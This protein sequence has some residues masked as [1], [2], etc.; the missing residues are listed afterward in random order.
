MLASLVHR[1]AIDCH[2]SEGTLANALQCLLHVGELHVKEYQFK[3]ASKVY[4]RCAEICVEKGINKGS[5]R[6]Y[7]YNALLCQFVVSARKGSLKNMSSMLEWFIDIDR[8]FVN[9]W[10]EKLLRRCMEAFEHGDPQ[11]LS[12][13]VYDQNKIHKL[14]DLSTTILLEIKVILKNP[15]KSDEAEEVAEQLQ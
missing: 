10:Q 9:T 2:E 13:A 15:P 14:D 3:K 8:K 4:E 1:N 7:F 5:L 12:Q 11:A 6:D